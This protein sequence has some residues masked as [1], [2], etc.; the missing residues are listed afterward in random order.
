MR[1][2]RGALW[3]LIASTIAAASGLVVMLL[4]NAFVFDEFDTYGTVKVPGQ[5]RL[6]LP[7]GECDIS[8]YAWASN[9]RLP[10]PELGLTIVPPR[11]IAQPHVRESIGGTTTVNG[12]AHRRVWVAQIESPGTYTVVTRGEVNGFIDP[13]LAFGHGSRLWW[14]LWPFGA[15]LGVTSLGWLVFALW[16]PRVK[17][18]APQFTSKILEQH[19]EPSYEQSGP[20][21]YQPT[22]AGIRLQHLQTLTRLRDSG[23][24]TEE[25]FQSEKRRILDGI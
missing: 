4:L 8:F 15:L 14:I 3:V 7:A 12:R 22:D 13:Q 19:A 5:Q 18:A 16:R 11:G 2:R 10:I 1:T 6:E 24:L 9:D 23:G 20:S 25:E 17:T 21:A